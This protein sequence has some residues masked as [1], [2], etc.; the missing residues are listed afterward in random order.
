[1]KRFDMALMDALCFAHEGIQA[2]PEDD[3]PF[4]LSW[5]D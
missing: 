5:H 3:V 2:F 4:C 1:M